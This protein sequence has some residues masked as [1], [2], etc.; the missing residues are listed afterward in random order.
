MCI[1]G[2]QARRATGFTPLPGWMVKLMGGKPAPVEAGFI[3]EIGR[4]VVR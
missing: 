3:Q 4:R 1:S 2:F